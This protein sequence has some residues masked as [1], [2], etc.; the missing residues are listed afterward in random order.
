[1]FTQFFIQHPFATKE[2]LGY[3]A[4]IIDLTTEVTMILQ[5]WLPLSTEDVSTENSCFF[6]WATPVCF[7]QE[8]ASS[9]HLDIMIHSLFIV[10][11]SGDVFMEKHWKTVIPRSVCDMFADA[12]RKASSPSQVPAI[13]SSPQHPQFIIISIL[14]KRLFFLAV[15]TQ[16]VPPLMIIELL[17]RVVDIFID[18]FGDMNESIMKE[19]CVVV[20]ELL[21]E[22]LDNGY[23]LVTESNILKELI[24]PPNILRTMANAVTGRSNIGSTLPS[25]QINSNVPWRRSGVKY[26]N[27]EAYFD[28]IEELDAIIDKSGSIV[29]AEIQG[30]IDCCVKLS[31]NPDLLLSFMNPRIFDDV[32]FHPCVRYRKWE[33]EKVLS[34]VPPDGNFRLMSYHIGSQNALNIPLIIKHNISFRE[35]SGGK[36]EIQVGPKGSNKPLEGLQLE[37]SMPKT[38]LS[39]NLNPT[40][41][42][43][44]F[45]PVTRLLVW[46]IGRM[47]VGKALATVRGNVV[48]QTGAPIPDSNPTILLRFSISQVAVSGVKVNR[49]DM[50]QEVSCPHRSVYFASLLNVDIS[51]LPSFLPFVHRNTSPSRE[52]ST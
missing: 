44:T 20:F 6:L 46:D 19:N 50:F 42:K 39:V 5:S 4:V 26:T 8:I 41:G 32:S 13:I 21:D 17:H 38:V 40:Q 31:G 25:G 34:F 28:V 11:E 29:S 30:Y 47:E 14:R 3:A 43:Y 2:V 45:D 22:M 7:A 52:S 48:L 24:K 33:S 9:K 10:S 1:M 16:E 36:M 23:P 37:V 12:Q 15:V 27:N 18:Y 49:L 35:S 51:F